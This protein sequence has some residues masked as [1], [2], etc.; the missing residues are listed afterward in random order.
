MFFKF[1]ISLIGFLIALPFAVFARLFQK[2]RKVKKILIAGVETSANIQEISATLSTSPKYLVDVAQFEEHPFY[3]PVENEKIKVF[4]QLTIWKNDS[5][6]VNVLKNWRRILFLYRAVLYYDIVFFNMSESFLFFNFDY[7][8]LVLAKKILIVRQCGDEVRY[9]PLQ[10]GIHSQFGIEQW[11]NGRRSVLD[12]LFK[13]RNQIMAETFAIVISTKDH[14][15]FQLKD[16]FVRPYIQKPLK[17]TT[18]LSNEVPLIIHAPSDTKIKGTALV[19][20]VVASLKDQGYHFKFELLTGLKNAVVLEKLSHASIVI[21]QPGAV[22]ARFAVEAMASGCV[23]IGGNVPEINGLEGCPVIPFLP[24]KTN[25]E[26]SLKKLLDDPDFRIFK[27][28][29]NYRYWHKNFS[30]DAFLLYF[31]SLLVKKANR[32]SKFENQFDL[33][34]GEAE[35]W[36]EKVALKIIYRK[37]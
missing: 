27:G 30:P 6:G 25:L 35:K 31:E 2:S 33:L 12:M 29:E 28:E 37:L 8:I 17:R 34:Y 15:T 24:Q 14:S 3:P 19:K 22:P 9:R 18:G 13:L 36:Y 4:S 7:P 11:Q 20:E 1:I 32:F 10:H 23:V 26:N 21:D 5:V 16:I